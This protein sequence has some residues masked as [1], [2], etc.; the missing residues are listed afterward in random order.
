LIAVPRARAGAQRTKVVRQHPWGR[1]ERLASS[2]ALYPQRTPAPALLCVFAGLDL[3]R[4][5]NI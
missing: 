1:E 4:P 5:H 3:G 2:G